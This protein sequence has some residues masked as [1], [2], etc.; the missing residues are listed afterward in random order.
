MERKKRRF[1]RTIKPEEF[2]EDVKKQMEINK[3][4]V[5]EEPFEKEILIANSKCSVL[6]LRIKT[7]PRE[8]QTRIFI[9]TMREYWKEITL[10]TPLRPIW[11]DSVSYMDNQKRKALFENIH[12]MHLEC[13][14]LENMKTWIPGCQCDFCLNDKTVENKEEIYRDI[15]DTGSEFVCH[16]FQERT[17]CYDVMPN[18]WNVYMMLYMGSPLGFVSKM[19]VFDPLKN[20]FGDEFAKI[21]EC[22]IESPIYF[23]EEIV[24]QYS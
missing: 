11:Y 21:N 12:F 24:S 14:T 23:S 16:E 8:V 18:F 9:I 1:K 20:Q 10:N 3:F 22:P 4:K 17:H 2:K 15:Y 13:N 5:M 7:L 6:S 19:K